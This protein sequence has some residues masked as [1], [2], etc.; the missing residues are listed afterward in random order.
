MEWIGGHGEG[1][2]PSVPICVLSCLIWWWVHCYLLCCEKLR[3]GCKVFPLLCKTESVTMLLDR[4]KLCCV[5]FF[6]LIYQLLLTATA[7]Y[8]A[9]TVYIFG[10][11][12]NQNTDC[13]FSDEVLHQL[14][15]ASWDPRLPTAL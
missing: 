15:S 11:F 3:L 12:L 4:E 1:C 13:K 9:S 8:S 7:S 5:V 6:L 2:S 14:C 10:R